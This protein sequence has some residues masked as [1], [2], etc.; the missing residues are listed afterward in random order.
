MCTQ[1]EAYVHIQT[2]AQTHTVYT[3]TDT[4]VKN[5][6]YLDRDCYASISSHKQE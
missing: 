4:A 6:L 5:H 3:H 2:Q 1:V